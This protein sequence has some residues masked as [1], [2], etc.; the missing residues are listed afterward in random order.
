MRVSAVL[1]VLVIA[2]APAWTQDAP[3][4]SDPQ[5]IF[6]TGVNVVRVDVIVTDRQGNPVTDLSAADFEIV[7]DGRPQPIEQFRQVQADGRPLREDPPPRA[8]RD[9]DDEAFEANREGVRIFAILLADYQVCWER[10]VPVRDALTRFVRTQIGR[11]DLVAVMRP[12]DSVRTL[13]FTYDHEAVVRDIRRFTG[14]KG[15]YTP[16]NVVESEQ[17]NRAQGS[18]GAMDAIRDAVVR[19]ALTALAVRV[20]SVRDGRK[21]I[22]FVSEG[23]RSS[24][25]SMALDIRE[26]TKDANRHNASIYPFDARGLR[27]PGLGGES[28]GRRG[29][30]RG[31]SE[32]SLRNLAD[33]TDGRAITNTNKLTEGLAQLVRDSSNYYLLGYTPTA[34]HRDGKFHPISV[35]VKR[36]NVDVR[37][38]K[39]YWAPT[40][41]DERRSANP[42]PDL[43]KPILDALATLAPPVSDGRYGR[44]WVGTARGDSGRTRVTVVWEPVAAVPGARREPA[45]R[46]SLT[47]SDASGSPLFRS[48]AADPAIP[49]ATPARRFVFDSPP[50]RVEL[51]LTVEASD[52]GTLDREI[53]PID[54]PDLSA[55]DAVISTPRVYRGRTAREI[56]TIAADPG[57]VPVVAREF[58]RTERLLIR[59]DA[60]GP[61][62]ALQPVAAVL[63]RNG[64][65]MF[66]VPVTAAPAGATHQIDLGFGATPIGDYLLEIVIL[67]ERGR[68]RELVAFRVRAQK[69]SRCVPYAFQRFCFFSSSPPCRR[70]RRARGGPTRRPPSVP[71]STS[72]ASTPR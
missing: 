49:A 66:D 37:A 26:V 40:E 17:W 11:G 46:V 67:S 10:S 60:Y 62:D 5:P 64:E 22:V 25:G 72:S 48:P 23:F 59:F 39:G 32:D 4:P 18:P 56:Q 31:G 1:A 47:A 16:R 35:R 43:A 55:P 8:M 50:G 28:G 19:D 57:A 7:E 38:R 14:R 54:V 9:R 41:E 63:N 69:R 33:D 58:A 2:S 51:R 6:R 34:S 70:T 29:C 24:F 20:G 3:A 61:G 44:T 27:A 15:D 65:K 45:G 71:A 30:P 13:T 42:T 36:S 12:L 52:G 68:V 21:S 53:R